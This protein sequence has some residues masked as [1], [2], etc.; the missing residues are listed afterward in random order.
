MPTGAPAHQVLKP[1]NRKYWMQ[2]I[3]RFQKHALISSSNEP[4][5]LLIPSGSNG[6][7]GEVF[8]SSGE[9]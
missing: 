5:K 3:Q 8:G 2:Y 9:L 1:Q 7:G 6:N 4:S